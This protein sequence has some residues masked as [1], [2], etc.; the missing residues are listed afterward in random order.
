MSLIHLVSLE[1]ASIDKPSFMEG[2]LETGKTAEEGWRA[3]QEEVAASHSEVCSCYRCLLR[4]HL[5]GQE[6]PLSSYKEESQEGTAE[7][8]PD[9]D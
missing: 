8:Q 1:G 7:K 3:Q 5:W 2:F 6:S 9:R 4:G